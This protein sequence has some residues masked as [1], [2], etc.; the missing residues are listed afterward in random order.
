[1]ERNIA[2][3]GDRR[4]R[5][6]IAIIRERCDSCKSN[7]TTTLMRGSVAS[8]PKQADTINAEIKINR[9]TCAGKAETKMKCKNRRNA[10]EILLNPRH[11]AGRQTKYGDGIN[12]K[13]IGQ[14]AIDKLCAAWSRSP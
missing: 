10:A 9:E 14:P 12:I 11:Y 5:K 4:A 7:S 2:V 1:M 8:K 3:R 13:V 6:R